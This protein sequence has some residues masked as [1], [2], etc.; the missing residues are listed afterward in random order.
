MTY[1]EKLKDPRWQ[2]KRLE[3]LKRDNFTCAACKATKKTLHVHHS[4]YSKDPWN[5]KNSALLT[6]C[7]DCHR[8]RGKLEETGRYMIG[9]IMSALPTEYLKAFVQSVDRVGKRMGDTEGGYPPILVTTLE[10]DWVASIRWW[11]YACDHP[12]ARKFYED[13]TKEQVDWDEDVEQPS[14][15]VQLGTSYIL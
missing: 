2:K 11:H 6:L 5:T 14:E 8:E 9:Q 12:E 13:V 15:S 4:Y 10:L 7:E 3:I 1:S